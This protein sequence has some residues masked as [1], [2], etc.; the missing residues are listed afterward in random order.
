MW[1]PLCTLRPYGCYQPDEEV[2]YDVVEQLLAIV[3]DI[4]S[5]YSVFTQTPN[6]PEIIV[7]LCFFIVTL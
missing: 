2:H 3:T 7:T 4:Q 1:T 5:F 6:I